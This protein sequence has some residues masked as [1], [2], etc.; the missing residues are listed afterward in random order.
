ML[1]ESKPVDHEAEMERLKAATEVRQYLNRLNSALTRAF[2]AGLAVN[3]STLDVTH[4]GSKAREIV[5]QLE[6]FS[7]T[8]Y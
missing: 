4:C 2:E 8:N 3:V 6:I 7:R 5:I 1:S